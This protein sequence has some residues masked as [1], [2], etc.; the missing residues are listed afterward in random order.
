MLVDIGFGILISILLSGC[1]G[2]GEPDRLTPQQ[3][4]LA[5]NECDKHD[6]R[7]VLLTDGWGNQF[8]ECRPHEDKK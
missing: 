8:I 1:L 5:I 4:R 7:S 2:A 6:L 3:M